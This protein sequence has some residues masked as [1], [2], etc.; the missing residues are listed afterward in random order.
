MKCLLSKLA[1]RR[2]NQ[3]G[4]EHMHRLFKTLCKETPA[5]IMAEKAG[6]KLLKD[7]ERKIF[8]ERLDM[9]VI[10]EISVLNAET[11]SAKDLVLQKFKRNLEL[12]CTK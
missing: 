9:L 1:A 3:F 2:F 10:K 8:L 6:K 11:W 7:V 12:K 5:S 4:G